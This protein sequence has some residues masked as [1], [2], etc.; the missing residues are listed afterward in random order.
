LASVEIQPI[1]TER[2][3]PIPKHFT[4]KQ[5][6]R[7]KD[8][9]HNVLKPE[10]SP[11]L[12]KFKL[13]QMALFFIPDIR[14]WYH[15]KWSTSKDDDNLCILSIV[16]QSDEQTQL[17][18]LTIDQIQD[19]NQFSNCIKQMIETGE[20]TAK[21]DFF[22]SDGDEKKEKIVQ[23]HAHVEINETDL[24]HDTELRQ[25]DDKQFVIYRKFA[26]IAIKCKVKLNNVDVKRIVAGFVIEHRAVGVSSLSSSQ[27]PTQQSQQNIK[28]I[29]HLV[30]VDFGNVDEPAIPWHS[31]LNSGDG[32][33]NSA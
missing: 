23:L 9:D 29:R 21:L 17:K 16:N 18:L 20:L 13:H 31:S 14:L 33:T 25:Q 2:L 30:L 3:Y 32:V 24:K 11:K 12:I 5:S 22:S 19:D 6:K 7:C 27:T 1:F 10:P 4:S 28:L 8:C 15:P 26:K